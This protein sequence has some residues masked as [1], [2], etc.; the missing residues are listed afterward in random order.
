MVIRYERHDNTRNH[1]AVMSGIYSVDGY[2]G[3][4]QVYRLPMAPTASRRIKTIGYSGFSV[5]FKDSHGMRLWTS[6]V[7]W[8]TY[9]SHGSCIP[10]STLISG[11]N[12][13][14]VC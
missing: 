6:S 5:E 14:S 2:P 11:A 1:H 3:F 4:P 10:S 7:N 8:E 13:M 12:N 9:S